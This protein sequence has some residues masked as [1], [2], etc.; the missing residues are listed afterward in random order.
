MKYRLRTFMAWGLVFAFLILQACG[1]GGDSAPAEANA[2]R[3]IGWV[4]ENLSPDLLNDGSTCCLSVYFHL[5]DTVSSTDV[6][7]LRITAPDGLRWSIPASDLQPRIS[8]KGEFFQVLLSNS[9]NRHSL[10]LAGTWTMTATLKDGRASTLQK[11]FHDPGTSSQATYQ[12]VHTAEDWTPTNDPWRYA[13]VPRRFPSTDYSVNY[14]TAQGKIT[15]TGFAA[16]RAAHLA[17]EPAVYNMNCWLYD[18]NDNYLGYTIAAFSLEDHTATGLLAEDGELSIVS[19]S[20]SSDGSGAPVDLSR[21]RY[22]RIV[23]VDGAQFVPQSYGGYD[24]LA[25]SARVPVD[26]SF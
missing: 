23:E 11:T 9:N 17:T 19:A 18:Q 21:V 16:A 13:P 26:I 1:G 6:D 20:T 7:R 8:S 22:I 25:V 15:T 10:P 24:H 2:L 5:T 14:F 12:Y 3:A 4:Y